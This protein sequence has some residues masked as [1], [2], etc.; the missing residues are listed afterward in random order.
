MGREF[1]RCQWAV[2]V[3]DGEN[4]LIVGV[5]FLFVSLCQRDR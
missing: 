4:L 2:L 3:K 1:T 5:Q